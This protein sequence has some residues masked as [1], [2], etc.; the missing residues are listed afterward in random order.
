MLMHRSLR[1]A[2]GLLLGLLSSFATLSIGF[3]ASLLNR[4]QAPTATR[5]AAP[6][7]ALVG[8]RVLSPDCSEFVAA[9]ILIRDT[10]IVE[11]G[12]VM[13]PDDARRVDVSGM[14][15]TPGLI[16]ARGSL[17][18]SADSAR[19]GAS[20]GSLDVL[21]GV[22]PFDTSWREVVRQGVT[23]VYVQPAA[24]GT[25]GGRGSVLRAG[26]ATSATDVVVK[27]DVGAQA[28]IGVSGKSDTSRDR[29]GQYE[30][31]KRSLEAA[32][33]YDD[34]WKRHE[35]S[36]AAPPKAEPPKT[37]TKTE[38]TKGATDATPKSPGAAKAPRRDPALDF[39]RR[40]IR[41]EVP[42]RVEAHRDD[43]VNHALKLGEEFGIRLVIEGV[44][45]PKAALTTLHSRRTPLVL[46][47]FLQDG[48][49][50][51][52][53]QRPRD[54]LRALVADDVRWAIGTFGASPRSSRLLRAH[55]AAAIAQGVPATRVLRALTLDA[56]SLLGVA[57]KLGTIEKGKQADL[58]V[59]AGEPLD[60]SVPVRL[61]FSQGAVLYEAEVRP[62]P[63]APRADSRVLP[64]S[65]PPAYA[66]RTARFLT[67]TGQFEPRTLAVRDGNVIAIDAAASALSEVATFDVGDCVLSAGL[68]VA[69]SDLGNGRLIDESADADAAYLRAVDVY[70]GSQ[71]RVRELTRGGFLGVAYA[72]GSSNVVAG[73]VGVVRPGASHPIAATE[74]G[75]KFVL[76]AAARRSERFPASL[77]GQF[78]F[79]AA[80]FAGQSPG[81]AL[82]VPDAIGRQLGLERRRHVDTL[83]AR[84]RVAFFE[85][86]GAAEIEAALRIIER[87][88]LRGVLV[89]PEDV[90]PFLDDIRRLGV[91]II[92]RPV[93]S[94]DFDRYVDGLVAA[95]RA[96]VPLAY[97]SGSANELRTTAAMLVSAGAPR[98][99]S[100]QGLTSGAATLLGL[101]AGVG[102]IEPGRA[103][104][105]VVWSGSPLDLAARPL[106]V[107]VDGKIVARSE[108]SAEAETPDRRPTTLVK[109]SDDK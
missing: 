21:D 14:F 59:F 53:R 74:I 102:N 24:T 55:A 38:P 104:D 101:P 7:I 31:I 80:V 63:A 27:R 22:D 75:G 25:L 60:A 106:A 98:E 51:E 18:L 45:N 4:G 99:A 1:A 16:D 23:S 10:T 58:A 97:G 83:L 92:A 76:T 72:P 35:E 52:S 9:T 100:I 87:F 30:Q 2:F 11:V 48:S 6:A 19:E 66:I 54:V 12:D 107:I 70:D 62:V 109:R 91:G 78:E 15:I 50:P 29:F 88:K 85:A 26:P 61:V 17:W 20:D 73:S 47:P 46:G 65:L 32:K 39:L 57:D 8:G 96:G 81:T 103:A 37:L 13:I 90:R 95:A 67:P 42:L 40:V 28:A 33:K 79:I 108:P 82:F 77:G 36:R 84:E 43:D 105:F 34:E 69:H 3:G 44:S 71:S 68:I 64:T 41:R 5:G 86:D 94:A 93:R 49:V 56:A 89:A